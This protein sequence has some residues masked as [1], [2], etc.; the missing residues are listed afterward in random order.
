ME[1]VY[2]NEGVQATYDK[3]QRLIVFN[4]A[5]VISSFIAVEALNH[6]ID[7]GARNKIRS[8][9]L[10]FSNMR[11]TFTVRSDYL[12]KVFFPQMIS[13]GLKRSVFV[14]S[15]DV[16]TLFAAKRLQKVVKDVEIRIYNDLQQGTIWIETLN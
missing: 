10:D 13:A 5:G 15:N 3:I 6:V 11:G 4:A 9:I 12:E 14:L 2:K 16:F 1:I 8:L 7:L